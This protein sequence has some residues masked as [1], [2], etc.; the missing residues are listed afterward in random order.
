MGSRLFSMRTAAD[1]P[2]P[3]SLVAPSDDIETTLPYLAQGHHPIVDE[4]TRIRS[5]EIQGDRCGLKNIRPDPQVGTSES[6][7]AR[8]PVRQRAVMVWR[9]V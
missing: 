5:T 2:S 4:S 7:P 3:G 9:R 8:M 6:E 1:V